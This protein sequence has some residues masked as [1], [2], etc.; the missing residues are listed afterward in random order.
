ME[1]QT[2][3]ARDLID[4]IAETIQGIPD[5]DRRYQAGR[6][7]LVEEWA[8]QPRNTFVLETAC[9]YLLARCQ[10]NWE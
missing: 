2:E 7:L 1:T 5:P 10:D 8:R 9:A 4:R 3:Q 6:A